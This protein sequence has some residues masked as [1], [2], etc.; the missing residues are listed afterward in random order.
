MPHLFVKGKYM[1][2]LRP[3]SRVFPPPAASHAFS[4][5]CKSLVWR[6]RFSLLRHSRLECLSKSAHHINHCSGTADV[7]YHPLP[8]TPKPKLW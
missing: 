8:T 5:C 1:R 3:D 2:R 7:T 6:L 4:Y